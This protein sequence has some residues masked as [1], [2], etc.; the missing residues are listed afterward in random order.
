MARAQAAIAASMIA[1]SFLTFSTA[2]APSGGG[3]SID[4]KDAWVLVQLR[5]ALTNKLADGTFALDTGSPRLNAVVQERGVHRID[6]ALAV[7]M[8]APRRPEVARRYGLD[9]IY[10]LHLPAGSDIEAIVESLADLPEVEFAEPDY[11]LHPDATFPNDP[12]FPQQWGLHQASDADVDAP[13]AWDIRTGGDVIIAV[14]DSGADATHIEF[15]RKLVAGWNFDVNS[16]NTQDYHGHG[17]GV[18]SIAAA[19]TDNSQVMA[20]VCWGCRVMPLVAGLWSAAADALVFAADNGAR[21]VNI[22]QG[23]DSPSGTFTSALAYAYD[24][25]LVVA[26]SS[27]NDNTTPVKYPAR[28]PETIAVGATDSSDERA[29]PFCYNSNPGSNYGPRLDVVAPGDMIVGAYSSTAPG[30]DQNDYI[31]TWCGTSMSSPLVAGGVGLVETVYPSAGRE[32]VR[33]L[34]RSGAEDGVGDPSEDI[35]GFDHYYGWGRVNLERTLRGTESAVSLRIDDGQN[36][37]VYLDTA[38]PLADSYDFVRGNLASLSESWR[39][40]DLGDVVCLENDSP[41]PDTAGNEDTAIPPPG[42]T[43]FYLAR[44]N[45]APGAG[46]Y[47]GSSRNR[48]RKVITNDHDWT[49]GGDQTYGRYGISVGTAGDV[50]GD[51]FDDLVVGAYRYTMDHANEGAAFVYLGSPSGLEDTPAWSHYGGQAGAE[52]GYSVA[53]AGDVNADGYD[54]VIVGALNHDNQAVDEGR[55]YVFLGS[56]SGLAPNPVWTADDA[57]HDGQFGYRVR[58]AGDV[59]DDGY[60]DVIV[61]ALDENTTG[62][63]SARLYLGSSAGPMATAAWTFL[64]GQPGGRMAGAGT[65][66]DFNGDGYDDVIV[67]STMYDGGQTDEGRAWLFLGSDEGPSSSPQATFEV[68]VPDARFGVSTITAGD[69]NNDGLDDVIIAAFYYAGPEYREGASFVYHGSDPVVATPSPDWSFETDQQD[70]QLY[71]A[72]TAGDVDNDGYDDIV[73]ASTRYDLERSDEGRVW[74]FRGSPSGLAA[75]AMWSG[76]PGKTMAGFGW[77]AASAGDV[78][79]DT[80]DDVAVGAYKYFEDVHPGAPEIG[81]AF[82]YH[83]PPAP[84]PTTDCP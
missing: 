37:R 54:D 5:S 12:L 4:F 45:G 53:T 57:Q 43:F 71:A 28:Y 72:E 23:T 36:T 50:N 40:V 7:T 16:N 15:R 46:S 61:A 41:D 11:F 82:V 60:D 29:E 3:D 2:G 42:E 55:A 27:G 6:H 76:S 77:S 69:V 75:T 22:S 35:T 68:D 31:L 74:V 84:A 33:H 49:A 83:G 24:A 25:G 32:E 8:Q 80:Y 51:G 66:G 21:V 38:N 20:G 39:G 14:I 67:G 65:A 81:R 56:S 44:F 48:D 73:V 62:V 52:F 17:S 19:N 47:G 34:I 30:G 10:R 70:A 9:R 59:N 26:V 63:G 79:G 78:N 1:L 64:H 13:E 58:T 18:S